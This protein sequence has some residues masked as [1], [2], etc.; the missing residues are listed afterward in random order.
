MP[1]KI[2]YKLWLLHLIKRFG[3]LDQGLGIITKV[4]PTPSC[5]SLPSVEVGPCLKSLAGCQWE[6]KW[7]SMHWISIGDKQTIVVQRQVCLGPIKRPMLEKVR[8]W[9]PHRV[10]QDWSSK[11]SF[12]CQLRKYNSIDKFK[13]IIPLTA[14]Q[15]RGRP[16][17]SRGSD[18]ACSNHCQSVSLNHVLVSPSFLCLL[19]PLFP[20]TIFLSWDFRL[21]HKWGKAPTLA[22]PTPLLRHP[23]ST[24]Y[25]SFLLDGPHIYWY[26]L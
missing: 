20:L 1:L 22:C 23:L 15:F 26:H 24:K 19:F 11:V 17:S 4:S 8:K 21:W 12:H 16:P 3:A 9:I 6:I 13:S 7:D 5:P 10:F 18:H 2:T 25:T 14:S